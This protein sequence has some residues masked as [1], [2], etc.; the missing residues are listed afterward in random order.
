V[1]ATV[2]DAATQIRD[3]L[4]QL[5]GAQRFRVWFKN[6]THFTLTQEYLKVGVPNLFVGNWIE[7]HYTEN[8]LQAVRDVAG[9]QVELFV[10]VDPRLFRKLRQSQLNSQA[11]YIA[12][13]A[14]RQ[15]RDARRAGGFPPARPLRARLDEFVV[16]PCNA[17]AYAAAMRIV[18]GQNGSYGPLFVHGGCGLGK[19][20]LLQGIHNALC[21][22][23]GDGRSL[24]IS[25][26]EF[27]NQFV[28]ALKLGKLDAFRHRFRSR[29]V[30]VIDDVHF[31]ANKRVTQEEFLHTFN[32]I[33]TAGQ[34]AIMASDT[35]PKL[36]GQFSP[37]LVNR[38]LAGI[39][40]RIDP[41]DLS[42]RMEI[43]R[44]KAETMRQQVPQTVLAFIAEHVSSNVRELEGALIKLVAY[45]GVSHEPMTVEVVRRLLEEDLRQSTRIVRFTDIETMV[46]T[47]FALTPADLH[48]SRKARTVAL[49]RSI[50][51]YLARK[52]TGMS[53][54]EIGRL[55]GNKNHST[56]ILACRRIEA[57]LSAN[58]PASWHSP[59][60]PQQRPMRELLNEFEEQ[61]TTRR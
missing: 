28:Y 38:F 47:H 46:A 27:T 3:R 53:Y 4:E 61:L 37:S 34:Q 29:S 52:L 31:L 1:G 23:N 5:V 25:G 13:D 2:A 48:T 43:L 42:T 8:L 51:M 45:A 15:A 57:A 17:L 16:G 7:A 26:E 54:P 21:G 49:A 6:T 58:D 11:T 24:Y 12:K 10:N 35:H 9:C 55:M 36:I 18:E 39:V 44:R 30:L 56:V 33:E 50:A 40:V 60:G 19:T 32:A 59:M 22:D 14:E 41:P 20:H